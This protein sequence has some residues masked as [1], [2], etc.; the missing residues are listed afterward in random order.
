MLWRRNPVRP[1]TS[2]QAG[3]RT[4]RSLAS[5][6]DGS[7]GDPW[8][9]FLDWFMEASTAPHHRHQSR[10]RCA[11]INNRR[12]ATRPVANPGADPFRM[13]ERMDNEIQVL[14]PNVAGPARSRR[15]HSTI[16]TPP[17]VTAEIQS[18]LNNLGLGA[19][20]VLEK[21]ATGSGG[22]SQQPPQGSRV[23]PDLL[24]N[25]NPHAHSANYTTAAQ[26]GFHFTARTRAAADDYSE[27][28]DALLEDKIETEAPILGRTGKQREKLPVDRTPGSVFELIHL[29]H[30]YRQKIA[31][32]EGLYTQDLHQD[33]SAIWRTFERV[34]KDAP[35]DLEQ[36]Q[37]FEF[38]EICTVAKIARV[39]APRRLE[40][41]NLLLKSMSARAVTPGVWGYEGLMYAHIG[42]EGAVKE[43]TRILGEMVAQGVV[44]RYLTYKILLRVLIEG[45]G[46]EAA[47]SWLLNEVEGKMDVESRGDMGT[48]VEKL[49]PNLLLY[50]GL[51]HDYVSSGDMTS[52]WQL[53]DLMREKGL[54]PNVYTYMFLMHGYGKRGDRDE[55]F[56]TFAEMVKNDIKPDR[57][58]YD[59]LLAGLLT[60]GR[61]QRD[62]EQEAETGVRPE[63]QRATTSV[64][65]QQRQA[66]S[67]DLLAQATEVYEEM[68][69]SGFK[70][71][72]VTYNIFM[73]AF[74]E[75][76]DLAK[77][78]ALF[79]EM[80][81]AGINPDESTYSLAIRACI[82]ARNLKGVDEVFQHMLNSGIE[83]DIVVY[84]NVMTAHGQLGNL[85]KIRYYLE[86]M[87]RRQYTPNYHIWH[88]LINAYCQA[89]DM[90]GAAA[91]VKR[92]QDNG[93]FI[94]ELTYNTLM[95][96]YGLVG[97]LEAVHRT[98]DAIKHLRVR[99]SI[100]SYNS[101]IAAFARNGDRDAAM[102]VYLSMVEKG[103]PPD[104]VTFNILIHMEASRLD[105]AGAGDVYRNMIASG[106]EPDEQTYIPLIEM[107]SMRYDTDRAAAI[108]RHML[109]LAHTTGSIL[110]HNAVLK[111]LKRQRDTAKAEQE[112]AFATEVH[113][114]APDIRTFDMLVRVHAY[115]GDVA[116]ARKWFEKA[117]EEYAITP[118]VQLW[119]ALLTAFVHAGDPE[120]AFGR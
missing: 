117:R 87:R 82:Y 34:A 51:V 68:K 56:R 76:K 19:D 65:H 67:D 94:T 41:V 86:D 46:V 14:F 92:M 85:E 112:F 74:L 80:T 16:P 39:S 69:D 18:M 114:V 103:Y 100:Y 21:H 78:R 33:R 47:R 15:K 9:T 116:S 73:H 58:V 98:F 25:Y 101:A 13:P 49:K 97:D 104:T 27:A 20:A 99:T 111:G 42:T 59:T 63:D 107:H 75:R 57:A 96:G 23:H 35:A 50:N 70:P 109:A 105:A 79:D 55:M 77:V 110:S 90:D 45:Q 84:G 32:E 66:A 115:K 102:R 38:K 12:H 36:L 88:I 4:A 118:D 7:P 10:R 113:N 24:K 53:V 43:C 26:R 1:R 119:N 72:L 91:V 2:C 11:S 48:S 120:G 17:G 93:H 28:I 44:P 106:V 95:H 40:R 62:F 6:S 52:A 61:R 31:E 29:L 89:R 22:G 3:H 108:Q 60:G 30:E 54:C 5:A 64:T 8:K 71:G 83:P 37:K 81:M